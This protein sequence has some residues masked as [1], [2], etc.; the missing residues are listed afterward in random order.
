[1]RISLI[2]RV[3]AVS[4]FLYA[5]GDGESGSSSIVDTDVID[6][7]EQS[8]SSKIQ[9][10]ASDESSSSS[11]VEGSSAKEVCSSSENTG[12]SLDSSSSSAEAPKDESQGSSSS[13][14]QMSSGTE[15]I[16]GLEFIKIGNQE[17]STTNL[18]IEVDG[19]FCYDSLPENCEKYGRLYT[20]SMAMG[21]DSRFDNEQYGAIEEPFQGICPDG[22]HLPS[23]KE[24]GELNEFVKANPE[25]LSYFT[26]QYG[27]EL[28]Y[29]G[30]FESI[31]TYVNFFTSTE[32][33][34]AGTT[35]RYMFAWLWSVR[36]GSGIFGYDN[37][38]K[39]TGAHVR[40]I[41][42]QAASNENHVYPSSSSAVP[43]PASSFSI[44]IRECDSEPGNI[45]VNTVF[46]NQKKAALPDTTE[47][48][49]SVHVYSEGYVDMT[50]RVSVI[51]AGP[52]KSLITSKTSSYGGVNTETIW[53]DGQV[54]VT[55]LKTGKLQPASYAEYDQMDYNRV[56]GT[57]EDFSQVEFDGT[58]WKLTPIDE[59]KPIL[60]YSS[61]EEKI[62]KAFQIVGDTVCTYTYAYFDESADFPG[63]VKD[64]LIERAVYMKDATMRDYLKSDTLHANYE[65]SILKI[66]RRSVLPSKMF[67][68]Y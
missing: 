64:I 60:Y 48:T 26:N 49:Y 8:S 27:G 53:N 15:K 1:M 41:K 42:G 30:E 22:T 32:Y 31:G 33:D 11:K 24:W 20:W 34:V 13:K 36:D 6:F 61:C 52:T 57:P 51:T 67:D 7:G 62:V 2:C 56:F 39:Q 9:N 28:N 65:M 54:R 37:S 23:H 21:I 38:Q 46:E 45:D 10:V 3:F 25:Y 68:L 58:L 63:A 43:P 47:K 16:E 35:Y 44:S 19:S 5:C 17:W 29:K 4:L 66:K 59:R 50:M 40:C 55:D 14:I 18:D 12:V